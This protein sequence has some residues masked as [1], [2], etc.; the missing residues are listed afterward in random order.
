MEIPQKNIARLE[1]PEREMLGCE[2]AITIICLATVNERKKIWSGIL[3]ANT[4]V[5]SG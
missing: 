4:R 5:C 1:F 3:V 2:M